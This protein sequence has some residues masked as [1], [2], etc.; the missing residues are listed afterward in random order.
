[1]KIPQ[2]EF[3]TND[4]RAQAEYICFL[5][6]AIEQGF[7]QSKG[8]LVLPYAL[9]KGPLSVYFPQLLYSTEFWRAISK[10]KNED[11]GRPFP[12]IC[13][14]EVL[15]HLLRADQKSSA[16]VDQKI[17]SQWREREKKFFELTSKFLN[18]KEILSKLTEINFLL[19]DFGA[20]GSF[21][22]CPTKKGIKIMATFR[23]DFPVVEISRTLLLCFYLIKKGGTASP[24]DWERRQATIDYL[25]TETAFAQLFPDYHPPKGFL[26]H[27][28][29]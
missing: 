22:S 18:L 26:N 4:L 9:A 1:M 28:K 6:K 25:F 24:L 3:I 12:Q 13:V 23:R 8:F 27:Q 2:V 19:T 17:I 5:A 20:K 15:S 11:L 7:Y 29:A 16:K 21:F 10:C 14:E